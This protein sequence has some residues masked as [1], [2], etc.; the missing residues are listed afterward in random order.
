[1]DR[2]VYFEGVASR[3]LRCPVE[4]CGYRETSAEGILEAGAIIM[5]HRLNE[6]ERY[7]F[8]THLVVMPVEADRPAYMVSGVY[9][10]SR[11]EA[12]EDL[13][14]RGERLAAGRA[15]A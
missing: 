14:E 8:S 7:A 6:E 15:F 2:K 9:D 13:Q 10:M 11:E 12:L 1:M 5:V 4:V 3:G